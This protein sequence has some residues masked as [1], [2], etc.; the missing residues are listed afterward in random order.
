M[1]FRIRM[2]N[3]IVSPAQMFLCPAENIDLIKNSFKNNVQPKTYNLAF[4]HGQLLIFASIAFVLS[5]KF[6][7]LGELYIESHVCSGLYEL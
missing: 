4:G 2:I 3:F 7:G 5:I 6:F 1:N